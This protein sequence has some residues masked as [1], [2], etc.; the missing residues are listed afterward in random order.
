M[1][2][3]AAWV[4]VALVKELEKMM[5]ARDGTVAENGFQKGSLNGGRGV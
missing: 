3:P 1:E 4:Q 2:G 5:M